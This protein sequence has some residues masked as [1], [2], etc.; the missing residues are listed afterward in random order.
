VVKFSLNPYSIVN[1]RKYYQIITHIFVHLDLIHLLFNTLTF[2]F[3]AP[4]LESTV[5]STFFLVLFFTSG[6]FSTIP[7]IIKNKHNPHYYSLGASGAIAGV[8]FSYI[9]FY[10]SSR[11]YIFM[12]PIGIPAPIFAIIYLA[13]CV[14]ASKNYSSN[15]N[16]EAHFW[17]ALWGLIFTIINYPQV[18]RFYLNLLEFN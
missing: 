2:F 18:I 15:I 12:F 17:G 3:F 1:R 7:T 14:Y 4:Q 10:P 5:N 13:Y 6:I 16:H 9:L 8:V 11:I